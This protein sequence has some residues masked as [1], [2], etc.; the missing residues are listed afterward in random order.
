MLDKMDKIQ[1]IRTI[2]NVLNIGSDWKIYI[3][4]EAIITAA[5]N[6]PYFKT[7]NLLK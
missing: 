7:K 5:G 4:N 1:H 2:Y 3:S 6:V